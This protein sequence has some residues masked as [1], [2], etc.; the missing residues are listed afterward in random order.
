MVNLWHDIPPGPDPP[1]IV[2]VV[3]E[4]PKGSRNKYEFDERGHCLA[5]NICIPTNQNHANIQK[6]FEALVPQILDRDQDS[7]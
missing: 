7:I 1:E 6:D 4:I 5:A 3:V 2:Y